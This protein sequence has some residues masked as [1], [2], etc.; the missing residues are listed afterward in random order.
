MK[1]YLAKSYEANHDLVSRTLLE[2]N[3]YSVIVKQYDKS[4]KYNEKEELSDIQMMFVIPPNITYSDNYI[5]KGL[6]NQ[7]FYCISR[8]VPVFLVTPQLDFI[9]I[10]NI[11]VF[12]INDWKTYYGQLIL[13]THN[14]SL[15]YTNLLTLL[16]FKKKKEEIFK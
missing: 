7:I 14:G 11:K 12:D 16:P 13:D 8:D 4:R 5:G 3:E 6:Y 1:I 15:C 2:L 10:R 9:R